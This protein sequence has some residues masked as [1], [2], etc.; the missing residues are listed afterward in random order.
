MGVVGLEAAGAV[1]DSVTGVC[2]L[3]RLD[4]KHLELHVSFSTPTLC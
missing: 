2:L 4:L 3:G 1:V